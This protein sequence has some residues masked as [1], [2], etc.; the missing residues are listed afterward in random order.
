GIDQQ[1]GFP[2]LDA[3]MCTTLPGMYVTG[4]AATKDFGPFFGFV[5]ASPAAASIIVNDLLDRADWSPAV[6]EGASRT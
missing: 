2:V 4:F 5:K 6:R 3:G 1:E